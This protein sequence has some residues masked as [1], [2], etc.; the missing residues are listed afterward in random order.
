VLVRKSAYI[1]LILLFAVTSVSAKVGNKKKVVG[2]R[3]TVFPFVLYDECDSEGT[4][5]YCASGWMGYAAGIERDECWEEDPHEG[6]T[7]IKIH[8][9]RSR[10]WYGIVWQDP[11]DDWG[12]LPGGWDLRKARKLTFWAKGAKGGERI[13]FGFGV[14]GKK[15]QFSDSMKGKTKV[16]ELTPE[17]QQYKIYAGGDR[18]CI[19]TGF[20]WSARGQELDF[21]F[22]MDNIQYED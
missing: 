6:A 9:A 14:I 17:W 13:E 2:T 16:F 4:I 15:K 5:P 7:C 20:M 11:P 10:K 21:T 1:W 22:Y 12:D 8:C 19:K 18:R 3:V